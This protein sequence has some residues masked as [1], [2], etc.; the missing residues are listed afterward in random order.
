MTVRTA[1]PESGGLRARIVLQR[2]TVLA[3]GGGS[4]V[5]QWEDVANLW[6]R[7]EPVSARE[8]LQG[9]RLEARI[10]HRIVLRY[11]SDAVAGMR[12]AW[13]ERLFR[14][15]AVT[16]LGMARRFTQLLVSEGGAL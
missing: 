8:V 1:L 6:A 13:Q 7:I 2:E 16:Q 14:V 9:Q 5:A 15:Q 12:V 3:Q 10:T 4:Y 11:R